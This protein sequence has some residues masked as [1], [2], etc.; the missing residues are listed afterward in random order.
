MGIQRTSGNR[1]HPRSGPWPSAEC[2]RCWSCPPEAA[3]WSPGAGGNPDIG[4]SMQTNNVRAHGMA[5]T[6]GK[7]YE[8]KS[9]RDKT[10]RIY[11]FADR[12]LPMQQIELYASMQAQVTTRSHLKQPQAT[13][14]RVVQ[15]STKLAITQRLRIWFA[16][17]YLTS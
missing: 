14:Q 2:W 3:L 12:R 17:N 7:E 5:F 16:C 10:S 9:G 4:E 8:S 11:L 6:F 1:H 15:A 13:W